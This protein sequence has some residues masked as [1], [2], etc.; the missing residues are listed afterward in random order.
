MAF[1]HQTLKKIVV[2]ADPDQAS[3][4]NAYPDPELCYN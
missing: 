4:I 3:Q 1:G 2:S